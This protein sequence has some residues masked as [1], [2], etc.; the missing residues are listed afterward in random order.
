MLE[1]K[2]VLLM[3]NIHDNTN[4]SDTVK[5]KQEI[6]LDYNRHKADVDQIIKE[7]RPTQ[8]YKAMAMRIIF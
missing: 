6:I 2:N 5:M 3:S 8:S 4:I 1:K 7:Y